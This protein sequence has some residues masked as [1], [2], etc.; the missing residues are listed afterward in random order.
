MTIMSLKMLISWINRIILK[1]KI[2]D[3]FQ[4][5]FCVAYLPVNKQIDQLSKKHIS[6]NNFTTLEGITTD[7]LDF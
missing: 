6:V 2:K 5:F 7:F 3:K 1:S 4:S